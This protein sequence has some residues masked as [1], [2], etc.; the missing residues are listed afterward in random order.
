MGGL[1]TA[2]MTRTPPRA[3]FFGQM[4]GTFI[5]AIV[6]TIAYRTYTTVQTI[7]SQ[8]FELPDG[9]LWLFAARP[10]HHEGLPT[11]AL[12]FAAVA[13]FIGS[14]FS[15]L[16][17]LG[18]D[19]WWSPFVPSSVAVA[20]GKNT[21]RSLKVQFLPKYSGCSNFKLGMYIVPAITLAR[22]L[23]SLILVIG[24][25]RFGINSLVLVCSATGLI[26][27]QGLFSLIA[28]LL[29]ALKTPHL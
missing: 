23:G 20:I 26:L 19:R 3:I 24:T 16:R 15:I 10:F 22:F 2:H 17:I 21:P 14:S 8:E 11:G 1:K 7:P 18:S 27:G 12:E 6:V 29:D 4:I 9:Q 25:K 13:F 5:G 28:L